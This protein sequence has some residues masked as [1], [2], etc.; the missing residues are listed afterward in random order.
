MTENAKQQPAQK[1]KLEEAA[2]GG[3]DDDLDIDDEI[4]ADNKVTADEGESV[5]NDIYVPPQPGVDP[6]LAILR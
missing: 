2:W 5:N 4:M 3:E 1:V 6:M